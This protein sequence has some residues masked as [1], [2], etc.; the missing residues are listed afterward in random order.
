M[1][2]SSEVD[3]P[4]HYP[5]FETFWQAQNSAGPFQKALQAAGKEKLRLAIWEAIEA[6]RLDDDTIRIQPNVFRYVVAEL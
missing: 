6:Y 4:F 3:C 2:Q 1:L 5:D